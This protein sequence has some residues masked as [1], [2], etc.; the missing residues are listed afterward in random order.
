[1]NLNIFNE[2]ELDLNIFNSSPIPNYNLKGD[3][4]T[5]RKMRSSWPQQSKPNR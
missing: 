2:F 1:M 4:V 5:Q 3:R